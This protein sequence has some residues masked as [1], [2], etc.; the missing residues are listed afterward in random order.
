MSHARIQRAIHGGC[1]ECMTLD[2]WPSLSRNTS[3]AQCECLLG[4]PD[5]KARIAFWRRGWYTSYTVQYLRGAS[6]EK[7]GR[8]FVYMIFLDNN[9]PTK[10]MSEHILLYTR[11]DNA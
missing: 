9:H 8:R 2:T 6:A 7:C 11:L 5:A 1:A 4:S 10:L 3:S